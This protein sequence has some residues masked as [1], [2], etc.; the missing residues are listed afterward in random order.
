MG[1][2]LAPPGKHDGSICAAAMLPVATTTTAICLI[3]RLFGLAS[4]AAVVTPEF[5]S[6]CRTLSRHQNVVSRTLLLFRQLVIKIY[7]VPDA[8]LMVD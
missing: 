6:N 1:C 7:S 2:T 4:L 5:V 8:V 3:F